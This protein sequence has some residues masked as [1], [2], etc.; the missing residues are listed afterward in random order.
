[1]SF[2]GSGT[3]VINSSGQPVVAGTTITSTAFNAL[4]A[5]LAV[6]LSTTI[7]KDGQTT[8]TASIPFAQGLTTTTAVASS[9]IKGTQ[10]LQS[11]PNKYRSMAGFAP[12]GTTSA[13][14]VMMGLG[15][16]FAL[17]PLAAGGTGVVSV[18]IMGW[19]STTTSGATVQIGL[20]Y[21]TGA[22]PANGAAV[23]GT[24]AYTTQDVLLTTATTGSPA[25][26]YTIFA[27]IT[28]L[29][30]GTAYWFDLPVSTSGGTAVIKVSGVVIQE[31]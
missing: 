29:V 25:I 30:A 24:S 12:T 4:T 20:R 16:S 6:G 31:V 23:T 21:G 28:G 7:C 3:F 15:S 26:P 10:V 22:A 14:A 9:Y 11:A 2:N 18:M 27:E 5:D 8:T 13:S 1:M 17:T 19:A